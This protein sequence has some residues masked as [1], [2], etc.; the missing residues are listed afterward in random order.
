MKRIYI[1]A[2]SLVIA[3]SLGSFAFSKYVKG[4]AQNLPVKQKIASQEQSPLPDT[5]LYKHLF[6]HYELLAKKAD[7]EEKLGK[8]GIS[9][10]DFY[11]RQAKLTDAQA[12]DLDRIAKETDKE[13]VRISAQ[14]RE[15]IQA[16]RSLYPDGKMPMGQKPPAP[17]AILS[18]LQ[19]QHDVAVEQGR[20][21]LK[22]ALGENGFAAFDGFLRRFMGP[23]V[24]V[25]NKTD[26][27]LPTSR[28][29][30]PKK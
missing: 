17:P 26:R 23:N 10:R 1:F 30:K 11:K 7:D 29:E 3:L 21:K 18:D 4:K 13:V 15:I 24:K 9:Y 6:H 25:E 16:A 20:D 19:E 8:D 22:Q 28:I 14:A 5:V 12:K 2:L 27:V